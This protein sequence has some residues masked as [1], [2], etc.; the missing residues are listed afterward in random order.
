[1]GRGGEEPNHRTAREPSVNHST[2]SGFQ[3]FRNYGFHSFPKG[4]SSRL[5]GFYVSTFMRFHVLFRRIE[6]IDH[7]EFQD[8]FL[9]PGTLAERPMFLV[10]EPNIERGREKEPADSD[11][12]EL[13][14]QKPSLRKISLRE[15][16]T[17][18]PPFSW[19]FKGRGRWRGRW[20][21]G[22]GIQVCLPPPPP[23]HSVDM[24]RCRGHH[25]SASIYPPPRRSGG[26][27][28]FEVSNQPPH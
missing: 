13:R 12:P 10:M 17:N 27:R 6:C 2:L 22:K 11:S 7:R 16:N 1:V 26:W 24:G 8:S 4:H 19:R 9:P 20:G 18:I 21:G 28:W 23:Q 15:F 3:G 5:P 25:S 14:E